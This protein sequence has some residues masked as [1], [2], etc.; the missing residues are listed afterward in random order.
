VGYFSRDHHKCRIA[1]GVHRDAR[2]DGDDFGLPG[3]HLYATASR[4]N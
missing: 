1:H 4:V 3:T 2:I